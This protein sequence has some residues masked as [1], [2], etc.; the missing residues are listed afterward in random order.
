MTAS[1]DK[2][3]DVAAELRRQAEDKTLSLADRARKIV[4]AEAYERQA[5]ELELDAPL[6]GRPK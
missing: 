5:N 4:L 6:F 2:L 3:R 1:S